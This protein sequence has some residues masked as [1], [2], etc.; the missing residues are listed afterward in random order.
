M[1]PRR[2]SSG[3]SG[4]CQVGTRDGAET[5]RG[6]SF[7]TTHMLNPATPFH[8]IDAKRNKTRHPCKR[9]S[10]DAHAAWFTKAPTGRTQRPFNRWA[11]KLWSIHP[12]EYYSPVKR[13]ESLIHKIQGRVSKPLGRVQKEYT[14][15][16]ISFLWNSWNKSV[17]YGVGERVGGW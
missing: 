16:I 13:T 1:L 14:C 3:S 12:L 15:Y 5:G 6:G 9:L 4:P 2:G 7:Y 17:T 11:D 8:P 10:L